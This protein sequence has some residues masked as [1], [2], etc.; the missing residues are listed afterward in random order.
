MADLLGWCLFFFFFFFL[1]E[2]WDI[3]IDPTSFILDTKKNKLKDTRQK[4]TAP[5]TAQQTHTGAGHKPCYVLRPH[6]G[7]AGHAHFAPAVWSSPVASSDENKPARHS[8]MMQG[9]MKEGAEKSKLLQLTPFLDL[10][11]WPLHTCLSH[12]NF[13]LHHGQSHPATPSCHKGL[14]SVKTTKPTHKYVVWWH[15]WWWNWIYFHMF[16]LAS[17]LLQA[18]VCRCHDDDK[19]QAV[20]SACDHLPHTSLQ[21]GRAQR[22]R[23][24]STP[25]NNI[26][27]SHSHP[28][29]HT[30]VS[31][32]AWSLRPQ[33]G[34][35][36]EV[37][38]HSW[39]QN[40]RICLSGIFQLL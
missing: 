16:L 20:F 32:A 4:G 1:R 22:A 34:S 38:L 25:I 15:K 2:C 8:Y 36:A 35:R 31:L 37:A 39:A 14:R 9:D 11:L 24:H 40:I 26:G 30:R 12:H 10:A 3:S 27:I 21:M 28:S 17:L 18:H 5:H 29:H 6:A 13:I 33:W 7:K 23:R 19:N